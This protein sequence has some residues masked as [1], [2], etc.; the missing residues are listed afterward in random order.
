MWHWCLMV[1]SFES[2]AGLLAR[3][4]SY[5]HMLHTDYRYSHPNTPVDIYPDGYLIVSST[6]HFCWPTSQLDYLF[7]YVENL[8]PDNCLCLCYLNKDLAYVAQTGGEH[9]PVS[10]KSR[11][12]N[13][14]KLFFASS[15]VIL[16]TKESAFIMPKDSG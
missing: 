3:L 2:V 14:R 10:R 5:E 1:R 13:F 9:R 8:T 12:L 11:D 16:R 7:K 15:A 4:W 6:Q